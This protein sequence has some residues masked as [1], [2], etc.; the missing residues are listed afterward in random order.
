[1]LIELDF[2]G[3]YAI[4]PIIKVNYLFDKQITHF[5]KGNSV[6]MIRKLESNF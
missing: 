1:M 2:R 3:H 5:L 6:S 4:M